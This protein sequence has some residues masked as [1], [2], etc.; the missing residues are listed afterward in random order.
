MEIFYILE[1]LGDVEKVFSFQSDSWFLGSMNI[2]F[3]SYQVYDYLGSSWCLEENSGFLKLEDR[4][5]NAWNMLHETR[6]LDSTFRIGNG[7]IS[8]RN[9]GL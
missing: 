6:Q 3:E 1:D 7:G 2:N 9:V 8:F 5:K 4:P